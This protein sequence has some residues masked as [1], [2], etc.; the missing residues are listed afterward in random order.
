MIAHANLK[1]QYV[2]NLEETGLISDKVFVLE[3]PLFG[4]Q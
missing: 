4:L 1:M 3:Q 2:D